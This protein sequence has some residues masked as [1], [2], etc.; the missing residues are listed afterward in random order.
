MDVMTG[1]AAAS[2]ALELARSLREFEKQL[3]D[4]DFKYQIAELYTALSDAKVSLA[5]ARQTIADLEAEIAKLKEI[6]AKKMRTVTYKGYSF[7]IDENGES[8]GRPFCPNCEKTKGL[9]IQ[10]TRGAGRH[11]LC[12]SC[13][14]VYGTGGYPWKLPDNFELPDE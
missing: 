9:Q 1:L 3:N 12:P 5:D 2:K 4:A 10:I 6:D 13:K 14:S 7:G 11:D 8:I